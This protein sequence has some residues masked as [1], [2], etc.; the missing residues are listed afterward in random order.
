MASVAAVLCG[1]VPHHVEFMVENLKPKIEGKSY[2][3]A[4][5]NPVPIYPTTTLHGY[6][7]FV[8]INTEHQLSMPAQQSMQL[9]RKYQAFLKEMWPSPRLDSAPM[10][11]ARKGRM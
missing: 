8:G 7:K 6:H 2:L 10:P 11:K 1:K 4:G 9:F 3:L 5:E